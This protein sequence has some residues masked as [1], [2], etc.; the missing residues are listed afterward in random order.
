MANSELPKLRL[1]ARDSLGHLTSVPME[2]GRF[3]HNA[4]FSLQNKMFKD[5]TTYSVSIYK[6][7]EKDGE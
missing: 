2:V 3:G 1:I 6:I 5:P 7:A 4:L